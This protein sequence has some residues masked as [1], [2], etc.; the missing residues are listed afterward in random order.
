VRSAAT[1]KR[2]TG[3]IGFASVGSVVALWWVATHMGW[4]NQLL[5]PSPIT[6]VTT[7][8]ELT[9]NGTLPAN[10]AVSLSRVVVGFLIALCFALPLGTFVGISILARSAV[11][12]LVELIRPIPP[13]AVIPL[14][15][16]WLGI[17]ELSKYS[18]VAYG[19]FFPIFLNTLTGF[20]A[21]DPVHVRAALTLGAT[22][23]QIFRHVMIMSAFPNIVVGA[24]IGMGMAF[25]VLV[26]A[27]LIAAS[28][29]LGFLI[30][31]AR[32]QYRMDWMFVGIISMGLLG[33]VL[34]F[35]L[36]ALE[37]QVLRWRSVGEVK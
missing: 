5:L 31:D 36:L 33:Y 13:I 35:G 26:A 23:W 11:I 14:A 19:A 28:S 6:V 16:L 17:G 15:I 21:V 25:V 24:R 32:N 29:G 37:R 27:E 4:V 8:F 30:M 20:A 9:R 18:I 12:P 10:I 7:M 2:W 34:N 1:Q 22:K 3:I